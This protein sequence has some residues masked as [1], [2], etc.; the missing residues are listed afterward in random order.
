MDTDVILVVGLAL[1]WLGVPLFF[2]AY[3]KRRS[4]LAA[5]LML[6]LGGGCI[7][8]ATMTHPEGYALSEVPDVFFTVIA[9]LL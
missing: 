1:A 9:R 3:A 6:V 4:P 5:V 2:S 8:W 7:A